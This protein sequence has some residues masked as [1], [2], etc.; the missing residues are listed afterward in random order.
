[1]INTPSTGRSRVLF[2]AAVE[3]LALSGI[4]EMSWLAD[5]WALFDAAVDVV[6]LTRISVL[7]WFTGRVRLDGTAN[8]LEISARRLRIIFVAVNVLAI[9]EIFGISEFS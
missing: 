7:V 4:S 6:A 8:V 1:M 9:S 5:V 2:D 3:V